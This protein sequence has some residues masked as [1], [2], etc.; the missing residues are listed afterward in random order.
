MTTLAVELVFQWLS[1]S[2][3][4]SSLLYLATGFNAIDPHVLK[5]NSTGN[6]YMVF[7][8]FFAGVYVVPLTNRTGPLT[9]SGNGTLVATDETGGEN[10]VEASWLHFANGTVDVR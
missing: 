7:G 6:Y 5:E 3:F 9:V 1:S 4:P 8:S 10:V 2:N